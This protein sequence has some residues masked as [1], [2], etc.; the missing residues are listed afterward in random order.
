MLNS[1]FVHDQL[2]VS[3]SEERA[4][5]LDLLVSHGWASLS[6]GL[7]NLTA[8]PD[9]APLVSA[10]QLTMSDL[11]D[12]SPE[13]METLAQLSLVRVSLQVLAYDFVHERGGWHSDLEDFCPELFEDILK[14]LPTALP[15]I[16]SAP[17]PLSVEVVT[18]LRSVHQSPENLYAIPSAIEAACFRLQADHPIAFE[19]RF[20]GLETEGR[21]CSVHCACRGTGCSFAPRLPSSPSAFVIGPQPSLGRARPA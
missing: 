10:L 17:V 4:V 20:E 1:D 13:V 9:L 15:R 21:V 7:A 18:D 14:R 12:L 2:C 3:T 8:Q 16:V 19:L 6:I 5:L 11:R